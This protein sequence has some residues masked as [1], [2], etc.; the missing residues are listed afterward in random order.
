MNTILNNKNL[1]FKVNVCRNFSNDTNRRDIDK[2]ITAK[3]L[4]THYVTIQKIAKIDTPKS[5]RKKIKQRLILLLINEL[6]SL[7]SSID[8]YDELLN[9]M[10]ASNDVS[11]FVK[12]L[13]F[14]ISDVSDMM[15]EYV[16]KGLTFENWNKIVLSRKK[17]REYNQLRA[18][19]VKQHS[20]TVSQW[21]S[22]LDAKDS[23]FSDTHSIVTKID[24]LTTRD[25]PLET[26]LNVKS[27]VDSTEHAK[28]L[29]NELAKFK[30]V[31]IVL[32]QNDPTGYVLPNLK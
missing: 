13:R 20:L 10:K 21:Y 12:D 3:V 32:Y 18:E 15:S 22:D 24:L 23:A 31:Q 14:A 2:R 5:D 19:A 28:Q 17:I 26:V 29:R 4:S 6:M 1:L 16:N 27:T 8:S 25:L 30:A 11:I 7:P 9:V